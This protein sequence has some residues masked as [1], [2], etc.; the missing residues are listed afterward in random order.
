MMGLSCVKEV[1]RR[2]GRGGGSLGDVAR[3][4]VETSSGDEREIQKDRGK[5]LKKSAEP[6]L[7]H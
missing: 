4:V 1:V 6:G 7:A 3:W 2:K 5:R